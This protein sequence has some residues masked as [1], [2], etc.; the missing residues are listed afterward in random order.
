[1]LCR[2]LF[3]FFTIYGARGR[4]KSDLSWPFFGV[5]ISHY[6]TFCLRSFTLKFLISIYFL[7]N[8][9]SY[10][11]WHKAWNLCAGRWGHGQ[12]DIAAR[13]GV[14]QKTFITSFWGK[15]PWLVWNQGSYQ[16]LIERH[17]ASVVWLRRAVNNMDHPP[18]NLHELH[19][20]L[21][22]QWP[23]IHVERM[24]C[25]VASMPRRLAAIGSDTGVPP[26][27]LQITIWFNDGLV[28]WRLF[29]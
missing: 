4:L 1:M 2:S 10:T 5:S 3:I 21:L 12:G 8:A 7:S 25:L 26:I 24:Q 9:P 11:D 18:H 20:A 27:R 15:L 13:V 19:Q 6:K 14:A 29:E 23:N 17:R 28:H 16:E 22:D